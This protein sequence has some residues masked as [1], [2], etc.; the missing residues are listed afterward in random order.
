MQHLTPKVVVI[1]AKYMRD[2]T[3]PVAGSTTLTALGI[4]LLDMPMIFLDLE[5]AFDVRMGPDNEIDGTSTIRT[6]VARITAELKAEAASP[7]S[8]NTVPPSS[9]SWMSTG[10]ERRR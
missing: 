6:L 2:R 5:D 1:L 9:G 8:R 4:D 3:V 7:R 10:A